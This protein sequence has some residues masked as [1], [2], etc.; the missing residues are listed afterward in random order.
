MSPLAVARHSFS[1]LVTAPEPIT[2]DGRDFPGLPGRML[3]LDELR[4]CLLRRACTQDTRDAVW[5]HLVSA[6]RAEG[7]V[8]TLGCVGVA[9]PAL[10]R[11]SATLTSRFAG[12]AA[13]IEAAVLAGFVTELAQIDCSRK[14]IMVRLRWA[15]Y[16]AGHAA[17]REAL[18][19]PL[20][21]GTTPSSAPPPRPWGH[22][23]IV[24]ARAVTDEVITPDEAHLI[25]ATRLERI[26]LAEVAA[27]YD[28]SYEAIKKKRQRAERK[29]VDYL[30]DDSDNEDHGA[31]TDRTANPAP[32]TSSGR[33]RCADGMSRT[34]DES[35]VQK[36]PAL[37]SSAPVR[38]E[39]TPCD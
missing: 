1:W 39:D 12:D 3:R 37:P 6:S 26:P 22:P 35:G 19:T 17:V 9:M 13:D 11:A 16:R 29:L 2:V 15:A 27:H 36:Y 25:G 8:W 5:A 34:G 30:R 7:A 20:P 24:L 38:K 14:K 21:T 18:D 32:A 23:D 33:R 4:D 31:T 10:I 28:V